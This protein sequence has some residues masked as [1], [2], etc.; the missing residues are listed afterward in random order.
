[1]RMFGSD[2]ADADHKRSASGVSGAHQP[3]EG[4][5][6]ASVLRVN[7][8]ALRRLNTAQPQKQLFSSHEPVAPGTNSKLKHTF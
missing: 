1:M 5:V 4:L 2:Q 3:I 7:A 8:C 6:G